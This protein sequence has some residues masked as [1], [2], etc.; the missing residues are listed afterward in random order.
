MVPCQHDEH[1]IFNL[2]KQAGSSVWPGS[3][4]WGAGR[5]AP[6]APLSPEPAGAPLQQE[7]VAKAGR[8]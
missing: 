2:G 6:P 1:I 3:G 5:G 8:D 7:G 4:S